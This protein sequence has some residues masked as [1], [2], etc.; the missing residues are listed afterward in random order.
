MRLD[1]LLDPDPA[2][3]PLVVTP[4]LVG[5]PAAWQDLLRCGV[6]APVCESSPEGIGAVAVAAGVRMTPTHRALALVA[7]AGGVLPARAV[8]AGAAAA[9]VHT[10]IRDGVPAPCLPAGAGFPEVAHDARV[11]RPDVPAGTRMHCSPGLARDTDDLGG[12]PVTS[13]ARTAAD[14]ACRLPFV[15]AVPLLEAYAA[16]STDVAPVDLK[17]VE[18][19][20]EARSRVVGRPAARRALAAVRSSG[21]QSSRDP[22]AP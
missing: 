15:H 14:V 13:P 16:G 8:L 6:L 5:G 9:W 10:G 21:R 17:R 20:L 22:A 4:A 2:T 18:R 1:Q 19:A 7:L 3:V 11:R 12:V